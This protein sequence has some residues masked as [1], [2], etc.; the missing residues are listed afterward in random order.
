[1]PYQFTFYFYRHLTLSSNPFIF[2]NVEHVGLEGFF[3]LLHCSPLLCLSSPET[4]RSPRLVSQ[5]RNIALI[6]PSMET[7]DRSCASWPLAHAHTRRVMMDSL[8]ETHRE[9]LLRAMSNVLSTDIAKSPML[10]SWTVCPSQ[11]SP[12]TATAR[13]SSIRVT[14][15]SNTRQS[16]VP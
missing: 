9:V 11:R 1:M 7:E 13:T 3:Y 16:A 5:S 15:S 6:S 10:R 2:G 14:P 8:P 4:S 12:T